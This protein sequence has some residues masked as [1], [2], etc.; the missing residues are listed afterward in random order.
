ME[1]LGPDILRAYA[2]ALEDRRRLANV[3]SCRRC[4]SL[5][6]EMLLA[7]NGKASEKLDDKGTLPDVTTVREWLKERLIEVKTS[8]EQTAVLGIFYTNIQPMMR[9]PQVVVGIFPIYSE[10]VDYVIRPRDIDPKIWERNG[11]GWLSQES[12]TKEDPFLVDNPKGLSLLYFRESPF[13]PGHPY[14]VIIPDEAQELPYPRQYEFS[15]EE[16]II[17]RVL[18]IIKF[19]SGRPKLFKQKGF[20]RFINSHCSDP[21]YVELQ[22]AFTQFIKH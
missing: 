10:R 15:L 3:E 17:K 18:W 12:A 19:G 13:K 14:Q 16:N 7:L 11:Q 20:A 1:K 22:A 2:D 21:K 5:D 4:P 6:Q 8:D 9:L